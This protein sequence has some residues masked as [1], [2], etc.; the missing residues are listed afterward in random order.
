MFPPLNFAAGIRSRGTFSPR[1]THEAYLALGE[2]MCLVD[3][4]LT[5]KR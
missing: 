2:L 3:M 4:G 5:K 1:N